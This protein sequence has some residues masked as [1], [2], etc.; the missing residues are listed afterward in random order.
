ML[1]N[2]IKVETYFKIVIQKKT[3]KKHN[4]IVIESKKL[5]LEVTADHFNLN[6]CKSLI[7]SEITFPKENS[8]IKVIT[9]ETKGTIH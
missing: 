5:S 8:S 3:K 1:K 9:V 2:A 4:T 6:L 7:L